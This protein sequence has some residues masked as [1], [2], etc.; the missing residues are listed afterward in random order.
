MKILYQP[1]TMISAILS[2]K[3]TANVDLRRDT[4]ARNE[5]TGLY[6][7]LPFPEHGPKQWD[8]L[9]SLPL[10]IRRVWIF[11]EMYGCIT[12]VRLLT[13]R[14]NVEYAGLPLI[15]N[16]VCTKAL[17]GT[18]VIFTD[19]FVRHNTSRLVTSH[20][21]FWYFH[22][23]CR[24][25]T[26]VEEPRELDVGWTGFHFATDLHLLVAGHGVDLGLAWFTN[27]GN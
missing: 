11:F 9:I 26:V 12:N 21:I 3:I 23:E 16:L 5:F 1:N 22:S 25:L 13:C 27:W 4:T 19:R 2:Q 20:S 8:S 10:N 6:E 24:V 7:V 14:T 15:S 17:Q 18:V